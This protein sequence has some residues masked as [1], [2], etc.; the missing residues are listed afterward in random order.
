MALQSSVGL[1]QH[2]LRATPPAGDLTASEASVLARLDRLGPSDAATLAR[3]EGISAQSVGATVHALEQRG[4]VRRRRD[5]SDHRRRVVVLTA[6][7]GAALRRRRRR[8][9]D[10]LASIIARE[11][12]PAERAR[13]LAAATLIERLAERL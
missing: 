10:Q 11:F 6:A 1:L 8:R 3:L 12:R 2:R 7:G 5:A 9:A 4:L 13:L